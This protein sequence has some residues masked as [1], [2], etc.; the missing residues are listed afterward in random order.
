MSKKI[1]TCKTNGVIKFAGRYA[2]ICPHITVGESRK[3]QAHGNKKCPL[4]IKQDA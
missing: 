3:C 2:G 1:K 4:M